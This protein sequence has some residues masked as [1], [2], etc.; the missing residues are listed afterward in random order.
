MPAAATEDGL[1]IV[2]AVVNE[3]RG[4]GV[5]LLPDGALEKI[6]L[7][8]R[9]IAR[10]GQKPLFSTGSRLTRLEG[11]DAL[12]LVDP[13]IQQTRLTWLR[14]APDAPSADNLI[15]LLDRL[16][17]VRTL[18]IDP[19]RQARIHPK[20]WTQI[21]REGDVTPAWLVADFDANRRRRATLVAQLMTL[22]RR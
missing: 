14:S 21:V 1:P 17:F 2:T 20:R 4:R 19:Q 6:G 7:A 12:L 8:G 15:G 9:A 11:L 18:A 3:F 5:L 22:D 16:T 10:N 13:A